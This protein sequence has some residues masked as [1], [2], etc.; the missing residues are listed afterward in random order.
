[1]TKGPPYNPPVV[2]IEAGPGAHHALIH[3]A[4]TEAR[5]DGRI[6]EVNEL[7][8]EIIPNFDQLEILTEGDKPIVHIVFSGSRGSVPLA[9]AGDG[10]LAMVQLAIEIAAQPA[11]TVLLE[12]PEVHQHPAAIQ[13]T[14]K[15]IVAAARRG[16]Q[17]IISTHS[18]ELIDGL[19]AYS[20]PGELDRLA[21]FR[22]RLDEGLLA[23][24]R[25]PGPRVAEL[26]KD[27]DEDLR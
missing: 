19:I 15:T 16:I 20:D 12:E 3:T 5:N 4:Y 11:G 10:V 2:L 6:K 9:F 23:S 14:A 26:R 21:V 8:K 17:V 25:I 13:R 18:L 1:M 27:I 22:L 7:L 24:T